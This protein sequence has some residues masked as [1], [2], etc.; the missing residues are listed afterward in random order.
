[1]TITRV[2]PFGWQYKEPVTH[3]QLNELDDNVA[4][5]VDGVEGGAYAPTGRVTINGEGFAARV[6]GETRVVGPDGALVV[7]ADSEGVT[8]R[9]GALPKLS[10]SYELT[11]AQPL[12][13]VFNG[14]VSLGGVD[15]QFVYFPQFGLYQKDMDYTPPVVWLALTRLPRAGRLTSVKVH[16]TGQAIAM[17]PHGAFADLTLPTVQVLTAVPNGIYAALS[18]EEPDPSTTLAEYETEH[19]IELVNRSLELNPMTY[20]LIRVTGESGA[21]AAAGNFAVRGLEVTCESDVIQP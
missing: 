9:D 14:H 7:D 12:V 10:P 3:E 2:N 19:T 1:M 21:A 13:V 11:L 15:P 18:T 5:A 17:L 16:V 20:M 8:F 4:R 6:S